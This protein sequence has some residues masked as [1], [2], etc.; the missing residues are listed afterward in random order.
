MRRL[1]E[2]S[3]Q[4][5]ETLAGWQSLR[6]WLKNPDELQAWRVLAT[7]LAFIAV[8]TV[9]RQVALARSREAHLDPFV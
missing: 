5:R 4:G 3:P 6:A 2:V 8:R 1:L 7:V 9:T